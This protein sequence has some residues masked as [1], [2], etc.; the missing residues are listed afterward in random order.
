MKLSRNALILWL[1]RLSFLCTTAFFVINTSRIY[2]LWPYICVLTIYLTA[3]LLL[4]ARHKQSQVAITKDTITVKSGVI[5][6]KEQIIHRQRIC[7]VRKFSTP[8]TKA[9]HLEL[10]II[11]CEGVTLFLPPLTEKQLTLLKR[12]L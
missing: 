4:F 6:H 9:L 1:W 8:F 3:A 11:F 7:A 2:S 5:L 10:P 12:T